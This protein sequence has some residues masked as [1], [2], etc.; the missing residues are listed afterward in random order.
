M[1]GGSLFVDNFQI[2]DT[3]VENVTMA[4]VDTARNLLKNNLAGRG[5]WGISFPLNEANTERQGDQPYQSVLQNMKKD[6]I[7]KSIS[8]SLWLN[9]IGMRYFLSSSKELSIAAPN[10]LTDRCKKR[11]HSFRGSRLCQIY[12]SADWCPNHQSRRK[13]RRESGLLL[14]LC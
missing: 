9:S 13:P 1:Y 6:G 8:Y 7:I 2:G 12:P 14:Y 4:I 11:H 3:I 5:I 10:S